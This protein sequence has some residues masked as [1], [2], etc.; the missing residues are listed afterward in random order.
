MKYTFRDKMGRSPVGETGKVQWCTT[1]PQCVE[2]AESWGGVEILVLNKYGKLHS[3][4]TITE[5]KKKVAQEANLWR[6]FARSYGEHTGPLG[7]APSRMKPR[8]ISTA[9][10]TLGER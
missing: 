9:N 1:L 2:T 10:T 8:R 3:T 4:L 5:A 7:K 6:Q